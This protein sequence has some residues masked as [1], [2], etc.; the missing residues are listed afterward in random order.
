MPILANFLL[1]VFTAIATWLAKY[2]TQKIAVAV[3][4]IVVLTA[5]FVALYAG[6]NALISSALVGAFSIHPM[7]GVGV[8]VVIS[9][10]T[11]TLISTYFTF[12]SA[13][14]LYKWKVNVMQVWSKTI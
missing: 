7:F 9:S 5:L 2:L 3:A 4:V 12:W 1:S 13:V 6:L 8:S 10:H 14:E 11:S